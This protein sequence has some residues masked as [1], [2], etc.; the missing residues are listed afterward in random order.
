VKKS[1]FNEMIEIL[2][3][4]EK[5]KKKRGGS[6]N[7]IYPV[8]KRMPS[9]RLGAQALSRTGVPLKPSTEP[10]NSES[11]GEWVFDTGLVQK[12]S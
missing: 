12:T 10:T 5:E 2:D 6:P 8:T 3:T 1:T 4:A 9:R 11:F 7:K